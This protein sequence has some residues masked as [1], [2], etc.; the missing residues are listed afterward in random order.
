MTQTDISRAI[1]AHEKQIAILNRL[2]HRIEHLNNLI[3]FQKN[4]TDPNNVMWYGNIG[5][6][7]K[8]ELR[9][10]QL[11]GQIAVLKSGLF[12]MYRDM[13]SHDFS[14][15]VDHLTFHLIES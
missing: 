14:Q 7:L 5:A 13:Y 8:D 3:A 12:K 1:E 4:Y 15:D 2:R 11:R 10:S 6:R 9:M